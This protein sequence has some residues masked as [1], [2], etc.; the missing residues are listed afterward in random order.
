MGSILYTI[1]DGT[2]RMAQVMES[3]LKNNAMCAVYS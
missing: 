2:G 3:R 1:S